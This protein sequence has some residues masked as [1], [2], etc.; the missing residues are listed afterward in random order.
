MFRMMAIVAI[1]SKG[2][3][4]QL[5]S[6]ISFILNFGLCQHVFGMFFLILSSLKKEVKR[7]DRLS[8]CLT[9]SVTS[10]N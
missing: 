5:T 3:M 9:P 2:Y 7:K 1:A 8:F 10:D 6:V 4:Y